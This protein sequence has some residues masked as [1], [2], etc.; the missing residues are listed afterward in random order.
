MSETTTQK[1]NRQFGDAFIG[2]LTD[3]KIYQVRDWV[4]ESATPNIDQL[5]T[6]VF[7]WSLYEKLTD[8][9]GDFEAVRWIISH[10]HDIKD[11]K[12]NEVSKALRLWLGQ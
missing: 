3:A 1:L 7:T 4:D 10:K 11:G 2:F 8:A 9:V 5:E 6:I 12:F